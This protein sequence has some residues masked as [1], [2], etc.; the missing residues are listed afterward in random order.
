MDTLTLHEIIGRNARRLRTQ[1]GASLEHLAARVQTLGVMT[2][3]ARLAAV[4]AGTAPESAYSIGRLI[5]LTRALSTDHRP[6]TLADLVE[7]IRGVQSVT[8]GPARFEPKTIRDSL[9]GGA[10]RPVSSSPAPLKPGPVEARV[11]RRLGIEPADVL[12]MSLRLWGRQFATERDE[13]ADERLASG[14]DVSNAA[15]V[16]GRVSRLMIEELQAVIGRVERLAVDPGLA[17]AIRAW[18]QT[19]ADVTV[20]ERGRIPVSVLAAYDRR[21]VDVS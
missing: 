11:A 4:E 12:A 10:A 15:R 16:R 8:I 20:A 18:A 14:P 13:R 2:D 17:A 19:Q 7:P 1:A 5:T 3:P 9:R 21:G 6:V